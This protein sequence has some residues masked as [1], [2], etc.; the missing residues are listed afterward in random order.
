LQ[1]SNFQL[2]GSRGPIKVKLL[3]ITTETETESPEAKAP[4]DAPNNAT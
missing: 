1:A 2:P 3:I 4:P